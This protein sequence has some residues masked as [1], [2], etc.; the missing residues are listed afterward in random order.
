MRDLHQVGVNRPYD[1][2]IK[3]EK[4]YE[5]FKPES[6]VVLNGG[7]VGYHYQSEKDDVYVVFNGS[8]KVHISSYDFSD[9]KGDTDKVDRGHLEIV[10]K[11]DC[12]SNPYSDNTTFHSQAEYDDYIKWRD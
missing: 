7:I 4:L 6:F 1:D 2:A 10:E 5:D 11:P 3:S 9:Y 12:D 8:R